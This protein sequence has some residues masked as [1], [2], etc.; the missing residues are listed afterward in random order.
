[1]GREAFRAVVLSGGVAANFSRRRL[2]YDLDSAQR[3]R[4]ALFRSSI[5][6]RH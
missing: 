6:H 5:L 4:A 3:R 1:M 2:S